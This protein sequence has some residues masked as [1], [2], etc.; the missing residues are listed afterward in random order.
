MRIL[1]VPRAVRV[2]SQAQDRVL[3]YER[4]DDHLPVQQRSDVKL[5]IDP[6]HLDNIT[7]WKYRRVLHTDMINVNRYR[8][9]CEGQ[10][11]DFNLLSSCSL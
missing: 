1:E 9:K 5:G 3:K 8:K 11:S 6:R 10:P 7:G 4:P 2:R